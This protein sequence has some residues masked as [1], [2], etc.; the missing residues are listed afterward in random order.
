VLQLVVNGVV[1]KKRR[2]LVQ[3]V[4]LFCIMQHGKPMLEKEAHKEL[5][6]VLN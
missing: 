6:D 5:F 2:K 3:F 4:T 1:G